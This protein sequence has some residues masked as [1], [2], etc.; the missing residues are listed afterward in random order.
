MSE[1]G[2]DPNAEESKKTTAP[3][4]G[5]APIS[6]EKELE[7]Q[8]RASQLEMKVAIVANNFEVSTA[9]AGRYYPRPWGRRRGG[10]GD[11]YFRL[12]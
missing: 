11:R 2:K 7:K 3:A 12:D 10:V 9:V 5:K 1:T 6:K 4:K 8:L